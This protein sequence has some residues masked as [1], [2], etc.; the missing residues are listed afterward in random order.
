VR[1]LLETIATATVSVAGLSFSVT[2]VAFTLAS[3]QLSPRVLRSFRSDR[4]SQA[5]LALLLGTFVYCL[6][7]LVRLGISAQ[8]AEPPNMSATVAVIAGVASFGLFTL[9][10][11]HIVQMLQPS[12]VIAAIHDDAQGVLGRSLET[13]DRDED[14][15]DVAEA[16]EKARDGRGLTF[17][18]SCD[19]HGY[20]T[21]I[22]AETTAA[23]ADTADALVEQVVEVGRWVLPQQRVAVVRVAEGTGAADREAVRDAVRRSFRFAKQRTMV[24]DIGFP[25]RQLA[26][27]ALKALSPGVNDPTT[28]QNAM[29]ELTTILVEFARGGPRPEVVF[30]DEGRPRLILMRP[31]L[32]ELTRDGFDAV[33]L[34]CGQQ[35]QL[36]LRLV[37]LLGH[38]REVAAD[39]GLDVEEIERQRR[40]LID[41]IG[42]EGPTEREVDAYRRLAENR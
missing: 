14:D 27:I 9:F 28:A 32:G 2:V 36:T 10:V 24:Q 23:G 40:L 37:E 12:S 25:I 15:I 33:R 21:A 3:Q 5:T 41:G 19:S 30:G 16:V 17:A 6:V 31:S 20:L 34:G 11:A 18:V 35:P 22:D 7:L 13:G 1:S 39:E 26:D 38:L 29:E 4:L 8:S 42:C